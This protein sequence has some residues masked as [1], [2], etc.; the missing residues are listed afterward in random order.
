M[1]PH[2]DHDP[3]LCR[4]G[5][6]TPDQCYFCWLSEYNPEYA[7]WQGVK[8]LPPERPSLIQRVVDCGKAVVNFTKAATRHVAHGCPKA[9]EEERNRRMALCLACDRYQDGRC[10]ECQCPIAAKTSWALEKCPL[11]E[12]KW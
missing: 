9:T 7:A 8:A 5:P 4:P 10:L 1:T 3:P 2:C 11:P 12:P 6:H